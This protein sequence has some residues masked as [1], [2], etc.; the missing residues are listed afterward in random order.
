M[1]VG[2]IM[3]E[4]NAA[5]D[6]LAAL[7]WNARARTLLAA[8]ESLPAQQLPPPSNPAAVS[9]APTSVPASAP[10][11]PPAP[12]AAQCPVAGLDTAVPL[13][14]PQPLKVPAAEQ[15]SSQPD[16]GIAGSASAMEVDEPSAALASQPAGPSA[17]P[18][19]SASGDAVVAEAV[20]P[21]PPSTVDGATAVEQPSSSG[22]QA[23]DGQR[24]PPATPARDAGA[25]P[26]SHAGLEGVAG[27]AI[28]TKVS[29]MK[30]GPSGKAS[31]LG[32]P[33]IVPLL[34]TL[35]T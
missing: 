13:P 24:P 35:S 33:L 25:S 18:G 9:P 2:L 15:P 23:E 16:H 30:L 34:C 12:A 14:P 21:Q 10:S 7:H 20:V 22:R 17:E 3:P 31:R 32:T 4:L 27:S 6:R 1:E 11:A 26:G 8:T 5:R 28:F 19:T 29:P